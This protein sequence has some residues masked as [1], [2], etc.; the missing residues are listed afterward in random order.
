MSLQIGASTSSQR[1]LGSGR[2]LH[3][4]VVEVTVVVVEV[5]VDVDVV[6]VSVVL[7]VIGVGQFPKR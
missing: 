2:P 1:I 6:V 5:L 4:T 3:K 7:V